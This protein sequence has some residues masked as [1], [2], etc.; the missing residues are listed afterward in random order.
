M[1]AGE[2]LLPAPGGGEEVT[3]EMFSTLF[4]LLGDTV[5]VSGSSSFT[6]CTRYHPC[7]H[8][9][10]GELSACRNISQPSAPK[11]AGS[12]PEP[13]KDSRLPSQPQVKASWQ[14]AALRGHK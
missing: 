10:P 1:G 14:P 4:Q 5:L 11:V 12:D 13:K 6:M 3:A 9:Q 2:S 8:S 7:G